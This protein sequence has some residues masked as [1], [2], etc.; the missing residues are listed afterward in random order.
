MKSVSG[1]LLLILLT[2]SINAS[3]GFSCNSG[4]V[5]VYSGKVKQV[6]INDGNFLL[7]YFSGVAKTS[8]ESEAKRVGLSTTNGS[9]GAYRVDPSDTTFPDYA[10]AMALS[11]QLT[12]RTLVFQMRDTVSGY[13]K[14]DR[15]W[16]K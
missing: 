6:Y 11:A 8:V 1:F 5:C 10:Y 7:I 2:F 16:M 12:D 9:A 4:P 14:I 15:I 3:A 13:L